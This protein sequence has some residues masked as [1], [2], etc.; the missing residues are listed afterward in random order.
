[1]DPLNFAGLTPKHMQ[2]PFCPAARET[3]S[4]LPVSLC[5]ALYVLCRDNA[6]VAG[7]SPHES[8]VL[9]A[10][11]RSPLQQQRLGF[12]GSW[13][14]NPSQLSNKYFKLLLEQEWKVGCSRQGI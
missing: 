9:S 1:M 13:D 11:P 7:L 2:C 12:S 14:S 3:P 10:R 8:V 6:K 5:T 4:N